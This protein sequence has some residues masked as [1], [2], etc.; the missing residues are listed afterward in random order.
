MSSC[1]ENKIAL[2]IQHGMLN[3]MLQCICVSVYCFVLC[4]MHYALV[5]WLYEN[6]V[7]AWATFILLQMLQL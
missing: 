1:I 7:R 5:E 3:Y 4:H 2:A 6:T